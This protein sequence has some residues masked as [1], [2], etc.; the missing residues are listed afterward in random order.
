MDG[1]GLFLPTLA[2]SLTSG[3]LT[4]LLLVATNSFFSSTGAL[5]MA[6]SP[7]VGSIIGYEVS[8]HFVS[9]ES[10]SVAARGVQVLPTAGVTSLGTGVF[11][12]VGR[13]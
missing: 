10:R 7:L 5:I 4:A 8:H 12:L 1:Q 11:G 13:F 3:G 2:G 6:L 9:R